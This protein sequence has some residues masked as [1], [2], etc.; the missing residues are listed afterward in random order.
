MGKIIKKYFIKFF[1]IY[2]IF[3]G[4]SFAGSVAGFGGALEITQ[5]A[6]NI[7]LMSS[8][9]QEVNQVAN[10]ITQIANQLNMYQNMLTNTGS[11]LGAP[12]QSA[13]QSI[14][15]LKNAIDGAMAMSYT[16]GSVDN[17]F[18]QLHPNYNTLFQGNNYATQQ[19]YWRDSV[20]TH[21]EASLKTAN[22]EMGAAQ[23]DALLLQNLQAR[24]GNAAGQKE[25][26][27]AGN[28]IALETAAQL[29]K[30][31]FLMAAQA[32]AQS[33]YLSQEKAR[34]EAQ[35]ESV[36]DLYRFNPNQI[37]LNDNPIR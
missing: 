31:K 17:Y 18:T 36:K 20:Y 28:E 2:F 10:Q 26:L 7:Q 9:V 4:N 24:S 1:V 14:M 23:N 21:T 22:I 12:F 15:Q 19:Q 34:Q 5:L 25:A 37:D 33:T 6:N 16:L 13:M 27:Q 3:I 35:D 8:Y 29:N 11:I 30:L 32:R